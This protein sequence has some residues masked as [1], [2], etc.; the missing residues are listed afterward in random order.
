MKVIHWGVDIVSHAQ[1]F[2]NKEKGVHREG[3]RERSEKGK[4]KEHPHTNCAQIGHSRSSVGPKGKPKDKAKWFSAEES[5]TK[6]W[7]MHTYEED[8]KSR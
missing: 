1:Q 3:K 6:A 4:T 7:I 8:A 5:G 2:K